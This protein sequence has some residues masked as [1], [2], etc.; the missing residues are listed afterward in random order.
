MT[1]EVL[2]FGA[3]AAAAQAKRVI[4]EITDSATADEVLAALAEQHPELRFATVGARLAVNQSFATHR[5]PVLYGDELAL[6]SLVGG[7]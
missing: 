2:I 4:V 5:T 6:I 1:V 3:A 7:G